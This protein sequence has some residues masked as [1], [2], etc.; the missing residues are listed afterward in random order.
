MKVKLAKVHYDYEYDR[1]DEYTRRMIVS[2]ISDWEE[3]SQKQKNTL[4]DFVEAYNKR[5]KADTKYIIF[6]EA[7]NSEIFVCID[8]QIEKEKKEQERIAQL[9]KQSELDKKKKEMNHKLKKEARE[10]AAFQRLSK[11]FSGENIV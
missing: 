9:K 11:K 1:Y 6:E 7:D 3:L 5:A 4:H 10:L 8:K 2:N